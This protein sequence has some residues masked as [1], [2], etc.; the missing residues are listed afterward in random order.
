MRG[1]LTESG[2][3]TTESGQYDGG[4]QVLMARAGLRPNCGRFPSTLATSRR[5][6][7]G[8][9]STL[10]HGLNVAAF[11]RAVRPALIRQSMIPSKKNQEK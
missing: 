10:W 7:T 1:H 8:A 9:S 11:G 3:R 4:A 6:K 2:R 5:T